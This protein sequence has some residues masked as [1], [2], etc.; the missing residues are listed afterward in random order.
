VACVS[1]MEKEEM[2]KCEAHKRDYF[3][4]VKR[5]PVKKEEKK[6]MFLSHVFS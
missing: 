2:T 4:N 5:N 6:Y 3:I 1:A